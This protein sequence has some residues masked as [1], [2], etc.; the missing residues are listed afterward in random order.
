MLR[1][2]DST[3]SRERLEQ[4]YLEHE[5][6]LYNVAYRYVRDAHEAQDVVQ[7]VFVK[8]WQHRERIRPDTVAAYLYRSTFNMCANRH[9]WRKLRQFLPFGEAESE[10]GSGAGFAAP[11][12]PKDIL[13][14]EQES[15]R[16]ERALAWLPHK[17]KQVLILY[18]VLGHSY[19]EVASLLQIPQGTVGSRRNKALASLKKLYAA[20]G[21]RS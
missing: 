14:Q 15:S 4:L 13:D 1:R 11:A 6:N 20:A 12:D 9:R 17:Q 18:D 5:M 3:L 2:Q 7:E 21:K 19:A 16:L 10:G 8:L